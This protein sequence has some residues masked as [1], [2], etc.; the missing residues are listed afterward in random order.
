MRGLSLPFLHGVVSG[1]TKTAARFP[2]PLTC[3]VLFGALIVTNTHSLNPFGLETVRPWLL[4]L[5]GLGFFVFLSVKLFAER[6]SLG[7]ASHLAL[8][9]IGFALI[10]L[11]VFWVEPYWYW[12]NPTATMRADQGHR[13]SEQ[14]FRECVRSG[15]RQVLVGVESGSQ[16]MLDWMEKD[17]SI[18][19]VLECA[20]LCRNYDVQAI[21]PFIVGFPEESQESVRSTL[22]LIKE[23]RSMSPKFETPVFYFKPYPGSRITDDVV[24]AGY[25]LPETLQEWAEFDFVGSAGPWVSPETYRLVERF[26]FYNRFAGGRSWWLRW[27]LQQVSRWRCR[28]DFYSFPVEKAVVERIKP[29]PQLS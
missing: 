8:A 29:Q 4:V 14:V 17:I 21:L 11:Q 6:R 25:S 9:A 15:L 5:F 19:Q 13:L 3:A 28:H 20:H 27:P 22:N 12:A 18:S 16:E 26:K 7:I 24:R 10:F 23:L 2:L 1:M